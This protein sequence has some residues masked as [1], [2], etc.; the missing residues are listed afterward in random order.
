MK[1]YETR[2]YPQKIATAVTCDV[3]KKT[4]RYDKDDGDDWIE[5]QEFLH[6]AH[7]GGYGSVFGDGSCMVL[8]ICQHCTKKILGEYLRDGYFDSRDENEEDA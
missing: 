1:T 8:D 4:W 5:T 3:C 6:I 2:T 7:H